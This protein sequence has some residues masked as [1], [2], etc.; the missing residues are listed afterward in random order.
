MESL[1]LSPEDLTKKDSIIQ[2]GYPPHRIDIMNEIDG[3]NF[4]EAFP[5]RQKTKIDGIEMNFISLED[6]K[7]NKRASGLHR[8]LD[9]LDDLENL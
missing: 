2:I 5:N 4:E 1:N 7:K 3:V 9:D 8:D 6:L